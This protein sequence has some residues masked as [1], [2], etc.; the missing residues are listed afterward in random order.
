MKNIFTALIA[1]IVL[2]CITIGTLLYSSFAWGFVLYKFYTWFVLPVFTS[3]PVINVWEAI[4][5][6]LVISLFKSNTTSLIKDEYRDTKT[7]N[8]GT[9][10]TPWLLLLIGWVVGSILIF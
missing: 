5:L 9:F 3:F 8:W 2:C 7:E 6:M 4:G 1:I 10:I